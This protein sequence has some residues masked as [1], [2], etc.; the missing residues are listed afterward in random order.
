MNRAFLAAALACA[1][2]AGCGGGADAVGRSYARLPDLQH[3]MEDEGYVYVG[4]VGALQ[5][6]QAAE[7]TAVIT[8]RDRVNFALADGLPH[9]YGGFDGYDLRVVKLKGKSGG[10]MAVVFRSREKR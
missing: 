8:G 3:A 1:V 10:D 9:E 4:R 6:G 2:A 7:V 5:G